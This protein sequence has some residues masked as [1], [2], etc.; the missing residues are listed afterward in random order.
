MGLAVENRLRKP[1][2]FGRVLKSAGRPESRD[3]L[4]SEQQHGGRSSDGLLLVAAI[5][6]ELGEPRFGLSVSNRVGNAVTRNRIKRRL[7]EIFRTAMVSQ[8]GD[9]ESGWDFVVT[10]RPAA[11]DATYEDLQRSALK[12]ISRVTARR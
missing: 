1:S 12:L 10:A 3:R 2:E 5:R 4:R 8:R 11:A 7:R 6:N 9:N